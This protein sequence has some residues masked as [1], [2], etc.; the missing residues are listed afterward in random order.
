MTPLWSDQLLSI[1]LGNNQ[2]IEYTYTLKKRWDS[3]INRNV[4]DSAQNRI[5]EDTGEKKHQSNIKSNFLPLP[6]WNQVERLRFW[7]E[8][9]QSFRNWKAGQGTLFSFPLCNAQQK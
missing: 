9:D 1:I 5:K 8:N 7:R 3:L 4:T 6:T 2:N